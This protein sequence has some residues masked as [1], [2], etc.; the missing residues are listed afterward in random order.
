MNTNI[1]LATLLI[2]SIF[3]GCSENKDVKQFGQAK[4]NVHK[5]TQQSLQDETPPEKLVERFCERK[6]SNAVHSCIDSLN[7]TIQHQLDSIFQTADYKAQKDEHSKKIDS[8]TKNALPPKAPLPPSPEGVIRI[9]LT[10]KIL[11]G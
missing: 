5:I 9:L 4:K 10:K 3:W 7:A 11:G 2:T 8:L 6:N 1:I